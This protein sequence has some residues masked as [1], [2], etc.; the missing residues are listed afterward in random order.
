MVD[1][2]IIHGAPI[3]RDTQ[4]AVDYCIRMYTSGEFFK[5]SPG[6]FN[7]LRGGDGL[8]E[9][10][11]IFK[12]K[13]RMQWIALQKTQL[14]GYTKPHLTTNSKLSDDGLFFGSN[15]SS[16][17][18]LPVHDPHTGRLIINLPV[19]KNMITGEWVLDF[20]VPP[21]FFLAEH[22]KLFPGRRPELNLN[23]REDSD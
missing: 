3:S 8:L 1:R 16:K 7:A 4:W 10:N 21:Y 22:I 23:S 9:A 12:Q 13:F 11:Y 17:G 2:F 20:A 15:H 19:S 6:Y 5:N 18:V 14:G